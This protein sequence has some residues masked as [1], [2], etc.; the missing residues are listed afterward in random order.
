MRR[1]IISMFLAVCVLTLLP[2][3]TASAYSLG[4]NIEFNADEIEANTGG[5]TNSYQRTD[6]ER[7]MDMANYTNNSAITDIARDY[8]NT[9]DKS[10]Q[11]SEVTDDG[12]VFAVEG[13]T[14]VEIITKITENK[15]NYYPGGYY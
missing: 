6:Q 5:T 7:Q 12:Y 1:K 8:I 2:F 14:P 4:E 9:L 13:D 11:Y 3:Q 10:E 15:G